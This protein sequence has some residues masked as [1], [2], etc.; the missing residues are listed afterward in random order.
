MNG[1]NGA[2][3]VARCPRAGG[4]GTLDARNADGFIGGTLVALA[5]LSFGP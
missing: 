3:V 4:G 5:A 2:K 1:S